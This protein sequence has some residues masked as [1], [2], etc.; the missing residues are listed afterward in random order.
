[1]VPVLDNFSELHV[2]TLDS[3]GRVDNL[4]HL[5]GIRKKGNDLLPLPFPDQRDGRI[6]LAP[7]TL[8][9]FFQCRK[10]VPLRNWQSVG[11]RNQ[12]YRWKERLTLILRKIQAS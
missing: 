9:E 12:L 1:M 3:V 8:R 11:R 4:S 5:G 10:A 6:F 7:G 2:Q